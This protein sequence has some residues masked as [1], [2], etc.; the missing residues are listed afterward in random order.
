MEDSTHIRRRIRMRMRRRRGE[1]FEEKPGG[2]ILDEA[3]IMAAGNMIDLQQVQRGLSRTGTNEGMLHSY[4][5]L[6]ARTY[7]DVSDAEKRRRRR[8]ELVEDGMFDSYENLS[9]SLFS[10]C[11]DM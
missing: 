10:T 11:T 5:G 3:A 2:I 1:E 4:D 9:A 8:I 7:G 6:T